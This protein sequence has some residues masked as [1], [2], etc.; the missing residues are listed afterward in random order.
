MTH[1]HMTLRHKTNT[2]VL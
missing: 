1:M 2:D